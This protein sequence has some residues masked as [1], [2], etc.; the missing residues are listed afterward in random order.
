MADI[1]KVTIP[2]GGMTCKH[3]SA[4]VSKK[5]SAMPGV[6]GVDVSVEKGQAIVTGQNLDIPGMR[7]AIEDLGFDAGDVS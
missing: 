5:L 7:Q 3:C 6:A 4:S 1:Q 2:I